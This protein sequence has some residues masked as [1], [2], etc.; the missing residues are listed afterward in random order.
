M[1]QCPHFLARREVP[2]GGCV[3]IAG[4][5]DKASRVWREIRLPSSQVRKKLFVGHCVPNQHFAIG[6]RP[7]DPSAV[8]RC[9]K[10]PD[11]LRWHRR[12]MF[13]IVY[14]PHLNTLLT[15]AKEILAVRRKCHCFHVFTVNFKALRIFFSSIQYQCGFIWS[16]RTTRRRHRHRRPA[17]KGANEEGVVCPY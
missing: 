13:A 15:A 10:I 17:I 9:S 3:E 6:R 1:V 14:S 4:G 7:R 5:G 12:Y 8:L 2:D 11:A 16:A